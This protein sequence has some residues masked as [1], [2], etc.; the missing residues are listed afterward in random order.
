MEDNHALVEFLNTHPVQPLFSGDDAIANSQQAQQ[1][2][3]SR[4]WRNQ[5]QQLD[6]LNALTYTKD[7]DWGLH[8]ISIGRQRFQSDCSDMNHKVQASQRCVCVDVRG[9]R[10]AFNKAQPRVDL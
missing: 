1:S 3:H 7:A 2:F 4:E 9:G 5:I 6:F 8:E 10:Q